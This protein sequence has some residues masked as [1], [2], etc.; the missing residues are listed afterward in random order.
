MIQEG[1][2]KEAGGGTRCRNQASVVHSVAGSTLRTA[3]VFVAVRCAMTL[4]YKMAWNLL[5]NRN[6]DPVSQEGEVN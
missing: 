4:R 1:K 5:W 6:K 3:M 2:V